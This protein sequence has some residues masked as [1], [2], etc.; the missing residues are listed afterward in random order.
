MKLPCYQPIVLVSLS[1][2][3]SMKE[4]DSRP[5]SGHGCRLRTSCPFV[6]SQLDRP[7]IC[8]CTQNLA[9]YSFQSYH[10]LQRCF[11]VLFRVCSK[12]ILGW[13]LFTGIVAFLSPQRFRAGTLSSGCTLKSFDKLRSWMYIISFQVTPM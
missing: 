2:L 6:H 12:F 5:K 9:R 13:V 1:F 4:A 3:Q 10:A 11:S 7:L 8:H